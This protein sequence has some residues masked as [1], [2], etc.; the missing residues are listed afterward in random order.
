VGGDRP[1]AI[2]DADLALL[3]LRVR[4]EHTIE[5][6][7]RGQTFADEPQAVAPVVRVHKRLRGDSSDLPFCPRRERA[8]RE[9]PGLH[10]D[11]PF[12]AFEVARD[13]GVRGAPRHSGRGV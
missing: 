10:R 2:D 8:D 5:C 4:R 7:A 11:P 13:D 6:L 9:E 12:A 1:F 3:G